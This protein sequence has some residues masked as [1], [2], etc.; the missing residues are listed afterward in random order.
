MKLG[1]YMPLLFT[2]L[3]GW[4]LFG[5]EMDMFV[6][7]FPEL[8]DVFHLSPFM[9]ELTLA[10]NFIGHCIACLIIGSL[11]DRYSYR[12]V[13][14][15]GIILFVIGSVFCAFANEYY[16]LILGR[17]LQ[18]VGIAGTT[19][20]S[21]LILTNIY[22]TKKQQE[23]LGWLNGVITVV[24]AIAPVIGSYIALI[25]HWRGNFIA[26][27]IMGIINLIFSYIYIPDNKPNP[28][29]SLSFYGYK[30]VL[31][32][33]KT[34]YYILTICFSVTPYWIFIGIS[35]ILYMKD[36][37]VTLYEFGFYQ[38]SMAALFALASFSNGFFIR[39]F[40]ARKCTY[41][42]V[43][44]AISF[45][46]LCSIAL[47]LKVHNPLIITLLMH[48][49]ALAEIAPSNILYPLMFE[50]IPEAKAKTSAI[51]IAIRMI[52]IAFGVQ[53]AGYF[54]DGTFMALGIIIIIG[55]IA[56]LWFMYKLLIIEGEIK[57]LSD[58]T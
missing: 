6:P 31:Q 7:S 58:P 28:L 10:S 14:L 4:I 52:I 50:V 5:T 53:F 43:V 33:K 16:I 51:L 26:L 29:A 39:K 55:T 49:L 30:V 24:M 2:L 36:L 17:F 9:V 34:L 21:Y 13:I 47:I 45:I 12:P 8:Q 25:F 19:T 35:P 22:S 32:S 27:L 38:G 18:G 15:I 48:I 57:K 40:G 42:G 1:K 56:M 20:L 37:G 23:I 11:G 44:M 41:F 54:Y 46:I 3:I